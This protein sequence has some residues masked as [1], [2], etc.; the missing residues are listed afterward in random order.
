[1]SWDILKYIRASSK[2]GFVSVC[3][4]LRSQF[5]Q[6]NSPLF[7]TVQIRSFKINVNGIDSKIYGASVWR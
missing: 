1:M 2:I 4:C 5:R 6:T 3:T 7:A